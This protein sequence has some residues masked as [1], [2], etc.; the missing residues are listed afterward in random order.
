VD[1]IESPFLR[2][3]VGALRPLA[4]TFWNAAVEEAATLAVISASKQYDP[5]LV[6]KSVASL[7]AKAE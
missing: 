4:L 5:D 6:R 1:G 2:K 3:A 7:M